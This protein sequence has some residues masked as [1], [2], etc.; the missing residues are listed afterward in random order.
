MATTIVRNRPYK[1]MN[2]KLIIKT[3]LFLLCL[4]VVHDTAHALQIQLLPEEQEWIK[5]NKT[6]R[7]SGPRA[8]PPFQYIDKEGS[9]KGMA[10]DYIL[11]IAEMVGLKI[12]FVKELPWPEVLDKIKNKEIDVLSCVAKTSERENFLIYTKPH[13]SFPLIIISRKDAPFM[14][15]LESLYHKRIAII[16]KNSSYDWLQRDNIDIVPHFVES[17]FEAL[18]A[19]SLGHADATI[20]NLAAATYLIE[21]NGLANLKIAAPTSYGNYNLSIAVRKDWPELAGILEKGL[22]ALDRKKKNEIRQK[23]IAVRY[24]HGIRTKDIVKW[25]LLISSIAGLIIG[26]F[27][28]W[29]RTLAKEIHERKKAEA[30]KEV[31]IKNLK[32]ALDEIETLKGILPLCSFCKKIR[33]DQG[34][35][36]QVDVY[37]QKHSQADISHGICPECM[38][39]H[40]REIYDSLSADKDN[41]T[42]K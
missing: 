18:K 32:M 6:I 7:V 34:Y 22:S 38:K 21:K 26:L 23:W 30:E 19:V 31:L 36:E 10:S 2:L 9:F 40:Y 15:G 12:E 11:V 42:K 28:I 16:R 1:I 3:T 13:L 20:R 24:E 17:P 33:N 35:W 8:F 14:S 4:L 25:I 27:Y 39:E 5:E 41:K 29:N 37:L